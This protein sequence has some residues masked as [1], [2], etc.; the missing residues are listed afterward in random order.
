[1]RFLK[2]T[3]VDF[4]SHQHHHRHGGEPSF[5]IWAH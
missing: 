4:S 1:L 5:R 3:V 2:F